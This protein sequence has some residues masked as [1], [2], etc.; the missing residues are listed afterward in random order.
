MTGGPPE[1]QQVGILAERSD[2]GGAGVCPF[3]SVPTIGQPPFFLPGTP[4]PMGL[5]PSLQGQGPLACPPEMPPNCSSLSGSQRC[6]PVAAAP[7][8]ALG[9]TSGHTLSSY[10]AAPSPLWPPRPSSRTHGMGPHLR[11]P[12]T[13]STLKADPCPRP[14]SDWPPLG[15][16]RIRTQKVPLCKE[17]RDSCQA[18]QPPPGTS[19]TPRAKPRPQTPTP[20]SPRPLPPNT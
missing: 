11:A 14:E 18:D 3:C 13:P 8:L 15:A 9:S 12:P 16:P 6:L 10:P 1:S 17:H 2:G 7:T 19:D 20:T 4:H 5:L